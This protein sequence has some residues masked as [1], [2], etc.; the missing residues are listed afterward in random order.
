M[1]EMAQMA[2]IAE[3]LRAAAMDLFFVRTVLVAVL[4]R[5]TLLGLGGVFVRLCLWRRSALSLV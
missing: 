4:A 5:R 2:E 3:L 1:A